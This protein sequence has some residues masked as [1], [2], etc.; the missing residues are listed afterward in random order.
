MWTARVLPV[1]CVLCL[2]VVPVA[3]QDP[4]DIAFIGC[5]NAIPGKA[6]EFEAAAKAH[7]SEFHQK[8]GDDW[9]W[10]AWQVMSGPDVG[11]T[12]WGTFGH[13]WADFDNAKVSRKA[14]AADWGKRT[15]GL[16]QDAAVVY[17]SYLPD[18]SRP[19]EGGSAMSAVRFFQARYGGGDEF[20]ELVGKFH[21]A[22]VKT[23]MPWNYDWYRPVSG[24]AFGSFTLVL[25]RENFAAMNPTGKPFNE[26]L[27]EAY[28]KEEAEALLERF[29]NVVVSGREILTAAR[30]DLS[31]IP[32]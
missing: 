29:N 31:Y 17:T 26:M 10:Y 24:A 23:E 3:A 5:S 11:R 22:I 28:G 14:D 13:Q 4:G 32:E 19:K 15:A 7:N 8:Q 25:P 18:I 20:L 30:P 27:E 16:D 9:T 12:C 2:S 6:A 1:V 21:E